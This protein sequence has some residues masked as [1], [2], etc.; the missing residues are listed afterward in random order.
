MTSIVHEHTE[1]P[2]SDGTAMDLYVARPATHGQPGGVIVLQEIFGVNHHI[3]DVTDRF[4]RLGYAAVAP[5]VFHR[6]APRFDCGYTPDEMKGGLVH[7]Q[8]TTPAG[9][10]ADL[11]AAHAH[12]VSL[13]PEGAPI[14]AVGFCMGGSLAFVANTEL[15]LAAAVSFYGGRIAQLATER[16]GRQHGP[17]LLLWGGQDDHISAEHRRQVVDALHAAG[18]AYTHLV[19]GSAGHGFFCDER[20]RY[21]RQ[22]AH[23]AWSLVTKFLEA[24]L[25]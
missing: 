16:A 4:A 3:R 20:A 1:V 7:A 19:F 14:A 8:A 21:D 9:I 13:L 15:P 5:D 22:S 23:E 11:A 25:S 10:S 24:T 17:L 12:L 6:T 2:C 18:K